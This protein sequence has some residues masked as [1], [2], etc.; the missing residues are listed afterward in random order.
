MITTG[1]EI[2]QTRLG[3]RWRD[4]MGEREVGIFISICICC[5]VIK[6]DSLDTLLLSGGIF[7]L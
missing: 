6:R 4:E 7:A 2:V 5:A 1:A 3:H